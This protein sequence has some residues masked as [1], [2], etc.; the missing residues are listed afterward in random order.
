MILSLLAY[1]DQRFDYVTRN[2]KRE[3]KRE[4][5]TVRETKFRGFAFK[6][7]RREKN[8]KNESSDIYLVVTKY[9]VVYQLKFKFIGDP[10][11]DKLN[12]YI[13]KSSSCL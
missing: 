10:I 8:N 1:N 9:F 5:G 12:S 7:T 3:T 13:L 2:G 4:T 6:E 11:S